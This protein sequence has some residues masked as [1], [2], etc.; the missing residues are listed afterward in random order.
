MKGLLLGLGLAPKKGMSAEHEDDE[1]EDE[2]PE[3]SRKHEADECDAAFDAL[4]D[5]IQANSKDEARDALRAY[6]EACRPEE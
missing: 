3:S 2:A 1:G 5:A 4:W 6:V